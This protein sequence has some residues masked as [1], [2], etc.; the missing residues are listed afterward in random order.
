[1]FAKLLDAIFTTYGNAIL[2][3]Q[4]D[5]RRLDAQRM[6]PGFNFFNFFMAKERL[7]TAFERLYLLEEALIQYDEVDAIFFQC[8]DSTLQKS[9]LYHCSINDY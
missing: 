1:M 9:T 3:G 6:L 4:E 8:V 2:T 5:V 7:A